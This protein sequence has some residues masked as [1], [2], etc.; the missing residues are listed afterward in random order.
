MSALEA[1]QIN[2]EDVGGDLGKLITQ[3]REGACESRIEAIQQLCKLGDTR[4]I[5]VAA[6]GLQDPDERIS[7]E[8]SVHLLMAVFSN[9]DNEARELARRIMQKWAGVKP[10]RKMPFRGLSE[11]PLLSQI[12]YVLLCVVFGVILWVVPF[13]IIFGL[14]PSMSE[15]ADLGTI[16]IG[17]IC[18]ALAAIPLFS[19]LR[20]WEWMSQYGSGTYG[21]AI[22]FMALVFIA[23]T[24]VGLL[25]VT[26]WTGKG[27]IEWLL[28]RF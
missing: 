27:A 21:E 22:K 18:F 24:L 17:I 28:E 23:A 2:A 16:V 6:E 12:G 14:V 3:S 20:G 5:Q 9:P 26:Y 25:P 15:T 7:K 11:T 13:A 10:G 19:V 8:A 1:V 4:A